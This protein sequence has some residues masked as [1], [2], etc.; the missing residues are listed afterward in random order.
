[1]SGERFTLPAKPADADNLATQL[2]QVVTAT[3]WKRAAIVYARVRVQD[4]QGRPAKEKVKTD[5]LSPAAHALLGIHGLRSKTTIRAYWRAWDNAIT[6]GLAQPVSL[7][8][9]VE[10]PE[11]EWAD[12]YQPQTHATP[13]YYKPEPPE[14]VRP[15]SD[16]IYD[17]TDDTSG[18]PRQSITITRESTGR[19]SPRDSGQLVQFGEPHSC[20]G[21]CENCL[22][23]QKR[24]FDNTAA[25]I[26]YSIR[27]FAFDVGL[28]NFALTRA[29]L[30]KHAPSI[31]QWIEVL[32][33]VLHALSEA[34]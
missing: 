23:K 8:D 3:E 5:L 21:R 7:G 10:L 11:A 26:E 30:A 12:Y 22:A 31:Q 1:M 2:G 19:Q 4:S 29:D 25:E 9:E 15:L 33:A 17:P 20:G 18:P 6:E 14:G 16:N 24:R 13:P 28:E 34:D 32:K 27:D